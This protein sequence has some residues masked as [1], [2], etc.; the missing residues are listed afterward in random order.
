MISRMSKKF[1]LCHIL[2]STGAPDITSYVP[3][4][5]T[6]KCDLFGIVR[7]VGEG[8]AHVD[9]GMGNHLFLV[10]D[11]YDLMKERFDG[12]TPPEIYGIWRDQLTAALRAHTINEE[13][14]VF[15]YRLESVEEE[16]K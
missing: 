11:V 10:N 15:S 5:A 16:K 7:G 1:I 14:T 4:L 3:W 6:L 13:H 2:L 8:W 9:L 12:K